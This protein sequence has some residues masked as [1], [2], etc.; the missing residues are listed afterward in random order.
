MRINLL[1]VGIL[2]VVIGLTMFVV[3]Q[4]NYEKASAKYQQDKAFSMLLG[5]NPSPATMNFWGAFGGFGFL[6]FIIGLPVALAGAVID[7]KKD[8]ALQKPEDKKNCPKCGRKIMLAAVA[9]PY[10]KH[11]FEEKVEEKFEKKEEIKTKFC[12]KCGV[13]I[14]GTPDFCFKC[15]YKM[16]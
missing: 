10:C 3:G 13:Q 4:D 12:P 16:R 15:G 8:I 5:G 7:E 1:V 2:L 11:D 6:L 14:D 9:C